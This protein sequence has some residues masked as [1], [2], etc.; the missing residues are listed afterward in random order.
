M[1]VKSKSARELSLAIQKVAQVMSLTAN[2][3]TLYLYLSLTLSRKQ[4][5]LIKTI[6][7]LSVKFSRGLNQTL[8]TKPPFVTKL[9]ANQE[10]NV[11]GPRSWGGGR[12]R[13]VI[14]F[15]TIKIMMSVFTPV[16]GCSAV[17]LWNYTNLDGRHRNCEFL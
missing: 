16:Q 6:V 8:C 11:T 4:K 1:F 5:S 2:S 3:P 10:N 12:G 7:Q 9:I 15:N 13:G 14:V 17:P